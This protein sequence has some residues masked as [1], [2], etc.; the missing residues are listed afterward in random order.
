M[1]LNDF[2]LDNPILSQIQD[3][4]NMQQRNQNQYELVFDLHEMTKRYE[5]KGLET[6]PYIDYLCAVLIL[7]AHICLSANV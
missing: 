1:S 5:M 6:K 3:N 4:F 7:Y 2:L